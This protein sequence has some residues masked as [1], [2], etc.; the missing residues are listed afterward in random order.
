MSIYVLI[1]LNPSSHLLMVHEGNFLANASV[2]VRW[3][4]YILCYASY[5][6][7]SSRALLMLLTY[8]ICTTGLSLPFTGLTLDFAAI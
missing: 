6:I 2:G 4:H 8:L 5:L 3:F 7:S 1:Y